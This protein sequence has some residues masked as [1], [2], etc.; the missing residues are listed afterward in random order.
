MPTPPRA[1][2]AAVDPTRCPL[3]GQGNG[4]AEEIA[5]ATGQPQPPCWCMTAEFPPTLRDAVPPAAR[6][7]PRIFAPFAAPPAPPASPPPLP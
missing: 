3:C 2:T 4:C 6:G 7:R 1:A 5:R